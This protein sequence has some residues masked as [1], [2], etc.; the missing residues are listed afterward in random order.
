[1]SKHELATRI[2]DK[3]NNEQSLLPDLPEFITSADHISYCFNNE[4]GAYGLKTYVSPDKRYVYIDDDGMSKVLSFFEA[5]EAQPVFTPEHV[6]RVQSIVQTANKKNVNLIWLQQGWNKRY[7]I[8]KQYGFHGVNIYSILNINTIN[9]AAAMTS[10]TGAA[11]MSA[12]GALA[13]SYSGSL[14]F[15][16]IENYIPNT[17]PKTKAVIGAMK[18]VVSLPLQIAELTSNAIFG[19]GEKIV[20]GHKLPTNVTSTFQLDKGPKLR[21]LPELKKPVGEFL[22]S[23][24]QRYLPNSFPPR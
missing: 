9:T 10:V 23:L 15:S 1:M 6:E 2:I 24:G 3:C 19:V 16:T 12:A 13:I 14:F 7:Y 8:F 11:A 20:T 21:N 5:Q 22:Y 4:L 17:L 18:V